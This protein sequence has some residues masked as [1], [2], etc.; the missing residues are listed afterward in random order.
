[1]PAADDFIIAN[2]P[3]ARNRLLTYHRNRRA[4]HLSMP[5]QKLINNAGWPDATF[6]GGGVKRVQ[7]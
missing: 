3:P 2:L 4:H 1:M 5:N 7:A 6:F